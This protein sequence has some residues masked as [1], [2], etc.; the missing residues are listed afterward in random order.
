MCLP[1]RYRQNLLVRVHDD[2]FRIWAGLFEVNGQGTR[3][4]CQI[5]HVVAGPDIRLGHER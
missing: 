1:A 4:T 2:N 3:T 5:E